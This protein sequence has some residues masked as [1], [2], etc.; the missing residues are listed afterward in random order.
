MLVGN[1]SLYS[2]P[3]MFVLVLYVSVVVYFGFFDL[4][5]FCI[6]A[7]IANHMCK[8]KVLQSVV[9]QFNEGFLPY[10]DIVYEHRM[11]V[12]TWLGTVS[13]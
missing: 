7:C 6:F 10:T 4:S 3:T 13:A 11:S 8:P 5:V 2:T 1:T 12:Y 9:Q